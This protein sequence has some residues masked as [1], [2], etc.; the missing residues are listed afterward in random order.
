MEK[1]FDY[2]GGMILIDIMYII[3]CTILI[4]LL[5]IICYKR[6]VIK[7]K[8]NRIEYISCILTL[9]YFVSSVSGIIGFYFGIFKG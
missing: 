9:V 1:L 8:K 5:P 2:N 6:Y 7:T 3:T 4:I